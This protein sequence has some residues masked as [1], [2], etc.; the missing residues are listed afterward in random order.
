MN[1]TLSELSALAVA[2]LKFSYPTYL[3]FEVIFANY[4]VKES[5][6][7]IAHMLLKNPRS[8]LYAVLGSEVK[9]ARFCAQSPIVGM[10]N[11]RDLNCHV[12][13]KCFAPNIDVFFQKCPDFLH[14]KSAL[15]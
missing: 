11:F 15:T 12:I 8:F 4:R 9:M 14:P 10:R 13:R 3:R 5:G 7:K 6:A 2:H 1:L